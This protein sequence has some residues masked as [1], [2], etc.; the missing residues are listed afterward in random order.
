MLLAPGKRVDDARLTQMGATVEHRGPD[1]FGSYV[2]ENYGVAQTR[3]SIL[4]LSDA[5]NQPFFDDRYS[6][7]YNGEI[8][9]FV[10]LG[11]QLLA[12]GVRFEG[13]SDTEVLFH[14]LIKFG[15]DATLRVLQGMFA[16]SFF[17]SREHTLYL[18][19]DRLG[20]K[21]LS[22][23][24]HDGDL[25][26]ASEVKALASACP[27][28]IDPVRLLLS[29]NLQ[30]DGRNDHTAFHNVDNVPPG[31]YLVIRHRRTA[32][33]P[34]LSRLDGMRSPRTTTASS[35]A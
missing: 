19:R 30:F 8:Y 21:P 34:H 7:V 3:L 29:T 23:T 17:D 28:E 20:I 5:G 35:T 24:S 32:G 1:N 15:V 10:D 14:H 9:N 6:L 16:F 13:T 22:Y 18:C 27:V 4:D 31:S 26:W 11:E 12:Q 33:V 25:F 2:R